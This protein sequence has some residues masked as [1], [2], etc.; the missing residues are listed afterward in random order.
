MLCG[1]R[2]PGA[3]N[4]FYMSDKGPLNDHQSRVKSKDMKVD[5]AEEPLSESD[6]I[7]METMTEL[8]RILSR[9]FL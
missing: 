7:F 1:N 8:F 5:S 2:Y 6:K 3:G 4:G 9:A